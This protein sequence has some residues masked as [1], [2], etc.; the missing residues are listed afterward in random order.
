VT[1]VDF[2]TGAP[3]LG[4]LDVR[5]DHGSPTRRQNRDPA[6]QV[7]AVDEHTYILRQNMAVHREAPFMYLFFGNERALLLDTGSTKDPAKFPLRTTIDDLINSWLQHRD[8][9]P[10]QPYTLVV[11]HTHAHYD[12]FYGDV[13]FADRPDTI[14]VGT[15]LA[16]VR[17]IF[18]YSEWPNQIVPF[19]L[20]G[21]VLQVLGGP[22]HE[23]AAIIVYDPWTGFLVTGDTVYPGRLYIKDP[24]AFVATLERAVDFTNTRPVTHVMGCHVEMTRTPGKDYPMGAIHQ[25]DEAPLP[26]T[27]QQLV[28][29]R[30]AAR[31]TVDQPGVHTYNDFILFNG[32]C[33]LA[34]AGHIAR[35]LVR[36][37]LRV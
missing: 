5:W 35:T 19:D 24:L 12:H 29:V 2:T 7:H 13:Q 1:G 15:D 25:P 21:R 10:G 26:M 3:I 28:A 16:A 23:E 9:R 27:V 20:G 18:G 32:P 34:V 30:D 36:R 8:G 37:A 4:D 22:G 14:V 31:T 11:A 17:D 33:R 6:I